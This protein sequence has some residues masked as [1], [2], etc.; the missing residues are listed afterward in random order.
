MPIFDSAPLTAGFALSIL[1]VIPYY[2]VLGR[3]RVRIMERRHVFTFFWVWLA[4]YAFEY[5]FL[6]PYSFI[7][8]T[9]RPYLSGPL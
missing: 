5:Y 6:G 8:K 2:F 9:G 7:E 4:L 3:P 1:A